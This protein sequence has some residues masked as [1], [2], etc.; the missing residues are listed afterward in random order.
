[1]STAAA[2]LEAKVRVYLP[3]GTANTQVSIKLQN[4]TTGTSTAAAV[5]SAFNAV[6]LITFTDIP[7]K[8]DMRNN[9]I[10]TAQPDAAAIDI[11][12]ISVNICST[13]TRTQPASAGSQNIETNPK[14]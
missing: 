3:L 5:V 1:V 4:S 10:L 13:R 2:A 8:E 6:T 7:I 12:I 14:P 9:F 11:D